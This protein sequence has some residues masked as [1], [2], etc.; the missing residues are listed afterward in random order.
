MF[1]A[2]MAST[3]SLPQDMVPL[4]Y[5]RGKSGPLSKIAFQILS[6]PASSAP[7]ERIYSHAG[8]I[9]TA[10]RTRMADELLSGLVKA[11]YNSGLLHKRAKMVHI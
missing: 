7:V 4:Q 2:H 11:K 1:D 3:N 10:K 9:V 5:W 8:L 6:V